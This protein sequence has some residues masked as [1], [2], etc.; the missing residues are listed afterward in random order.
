MTSTEFIQQ[1]TRPH[2]RQFAEYVAKRYR[3][4]SYGVYLRKPRSIEYNPRSEEEGKKGNHRR[5]V[6][7]AT[8]GLRFVGEAHVIAKLRHTGW[9]CDSSQD[10][11]AKGGVWQLPGHAGKPLFVA[12]VIGSRDRAVMPSQSRYRPM[13]WSVR[14]VVNPVVAAL[15]MSSVAVVGAEIGK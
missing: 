15:P 3:V 12:G 10:E 2:T 13:R 11:V 4:E 1:S 8:A 5:W 7:N 14:S 9:F 6:E